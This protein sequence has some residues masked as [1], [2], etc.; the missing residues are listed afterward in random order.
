ML[1]IWFKCYIWKLHLV[2][3]HNCSVNPWN[4]DETHSVVLHINSCSFFHWSSSKGGTNS[5]A[6]FLWCGQRNV[7]MWTRTLYTR[8]LVL[9][10]EQETL[11]SY[12][13]KRHS[14]WQTPSGKRLLAGTDHEGCRAC[15]SRAGVT[16]CRLANST[17]LTLRGTLSHICDIWQSWLFKRTKYN[18]CSFARLILRKKH[19]SLYLFSIIEAILCFVGHI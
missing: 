16:E 19:H 2:L 3:L 1:W 6:S 7:L 18:S 9:P 11:S 15:P 5:L 13:C 4:S 14:S 12:L 8:A 17:S 10:Q